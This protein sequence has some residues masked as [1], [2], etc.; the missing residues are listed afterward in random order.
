VDA[1]REKLSDERLGEPSAAIQARVAAAR[2]SLRSQRLR[3]VGTVLLTNADM[4]PAEV[5][6]YCTLDDAGRSLL[7]AAT[8]VS[9]CR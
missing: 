3:F 8:L 7:R 4:G 5:R 1:K 6:E 9:S 2:D